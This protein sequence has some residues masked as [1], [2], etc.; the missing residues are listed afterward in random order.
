MACASQSN[1]NIERSSYTKNSNSVGSIMASSS[2]TLSS[3]DLPKKAYRIKAIDFCELSD[4]PSG[5]SHLILFGDGINKLSGWNHI[6]KPEFTS[7]FA[8]INQ[9]PSAAAYSIK[10]PLITLQ[11]ADESNNINAYPN[12]I[13]Q[14]VFPITLVKKYGDSSHKHSNGIQNTISNIIYGELDKIRLY[15]KFDSTT[16]KI[17]TFAQLKNR[18]GSILNDD[19]LNKLYDPNLSIKLTFAA[20]NTKDSQDFI[21]DTIVKVDLKYLDHWV[22][23]EVD[24]A[25]MSFYAGQWFKRLPKLLANNLN[26]KVTKFKITAEAYGT[27]TDPEKQGKTAKDLSKINASAWQDLGLEELYK[28]LSV[29]IARMEVITK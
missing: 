16:S 2:S 7:E 15:V 24:V 10:K 19:E 23:I 26:T 17:P 28:E 8:N 29:V 11:P 18:Y 20:T 14:K 12:C 25:Q 13:A 5:P 9:G 3:I 22:L 27:Q 1:E 6:S 4:T 21:G